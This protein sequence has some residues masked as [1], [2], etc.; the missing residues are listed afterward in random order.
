MVV[1]PIL[2]VLVSPWDRLKLNLYIGQ[3]VYL[4]SPD[5]YEVLYDLYL[6]IFFV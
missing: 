4:N 2:W 3:K 1:H 6:S 5:L